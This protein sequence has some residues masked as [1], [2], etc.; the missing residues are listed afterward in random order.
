MTSPELVRGL[1][2]RAARAL[3]AQ[4]VEDVAGWWLRYAPGCA[5]WAGTVLPHGEA[6]PVELLSRIIEAEKFYAGRGATARFQVSPPACPAGLDTLLAER[7]YR[8]GS[9]MS[10]RVASTAQVL[11]RVSAGPLRV[12]VDDSPTGAWFDSWHAVNGHGGDS[13]SGPRRGGGSR[14]SSRA[15]VR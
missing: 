13:R 2:E 11:E 10:L 4:H 7:G 8:R 5:W 1:Q 14:S 15:S 3:P 9:P 12:G 6:G